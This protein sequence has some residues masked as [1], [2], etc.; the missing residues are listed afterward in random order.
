MKKKHFVQQ[1]ST[2]Q[3]NTMKLIINENKKRMKLFCGYFEFRRKGSNKNQK[4]VFIRSLAS[5][6]TS[7]HSV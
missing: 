1:H 4:C 5:Y 3:A 2:H 7:A 6:L